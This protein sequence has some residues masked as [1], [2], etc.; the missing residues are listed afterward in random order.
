VHDYLNLARSGQMIASGLHA[1]TLP[2]L[3]EILLSPPP[4]AEEEALA[5]LGVT[6]FVAV[7]R[8]GFDTRRRVS[9]VHA[10]ARADAPVL[11]RW[12][13]QSDTFQP[14]ADLDAYAAPQER[15]ALKGL[16]QDLLRRGV[17]RLEQVRAAYLDFLATR[18]ASR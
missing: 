15:A 6:L 17:R 3:R 9:A 12:D 1:D 5:A 10:G 13:E 11:F 7:D 18:K 2:Q 8:R 14:Q 16:L 4:E